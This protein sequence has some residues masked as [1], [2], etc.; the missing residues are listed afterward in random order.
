M[1]PKEILRDAKD[2][3]NNYPGDR[4]RLTGA[5]ILALVS[6][7]NPNFVIVPEEERPGNRGSKCTCVSGCKSWTCDKI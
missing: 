1:T 6:F 4:L 3:V 5:E 2:M 7:V